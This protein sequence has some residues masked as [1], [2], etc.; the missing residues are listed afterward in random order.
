MV[1]IELPRENARIRRGLMLIT[2]IIQNLANNVLFGKEPYLIPLNNLLEANIVPL[3]RF[4]NDSIVSNMSVHTIGVLIAS[5]LTQHYTP[6][7]DEEVVEEW[8]G[9]SYD[10]VD[11]AVLHRYFSDHVD[12]IGKDLLTTGKPASSQ[13]TDTI[14]GKRQWDMLVNVLV[15][16]GQPVEVPVLSRNSSEDHGPYKTFMRSQAHRT[17][18]ASIRDTF[19]EAPGVKVFCGYRKPLPNEVLILLWQ[20]GTTIPSTEH[21]SLDPEETPNVYIFRIAQLNVETVEFHLLLFR[22]FSVSLMFTWS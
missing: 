20:N 22:I 5:W 18:D 1:D 9:T 4:L 7:P 17:P 19:I 13:A 2:K 16:L 12:K 3:A 10:E 8:L 14:A 6:L 11:Q 15:E 21:R